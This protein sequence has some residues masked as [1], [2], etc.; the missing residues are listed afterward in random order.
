MKGVRP[1]MRMA[2]DRRRER[3]ARSRLLPDKNRLCNAPESG[4]AG[5]YERHGAARAEVPES[6]HAPV[7][8]AYQGAW[9]F[10]GLEP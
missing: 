5:R 9:T 3:A 10:D 6:G 7:C 4:A 1:E 8:N 2:P